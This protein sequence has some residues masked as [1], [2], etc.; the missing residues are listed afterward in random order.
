MLAGTIQN[1]SALETRPTIIGNDLNTRP[2]IIEKP[3]FLQ[4]IA[5]KKPEL[6]SSSPFEDKNLM[7]LESQSNSSDGDFDFEEIKKI[8]GTPNK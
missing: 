3:S 7:R 8:H 4:K 6:P 2:T 1:D 5:E